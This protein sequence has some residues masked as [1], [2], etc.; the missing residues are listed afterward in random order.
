[1]TFAVVTEATASYIS[2]TAYL[3]VLMGSAILSSRLSRYLGGVA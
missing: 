2:T 3:A 1:M